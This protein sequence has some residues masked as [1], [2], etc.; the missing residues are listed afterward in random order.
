[1]K[2]GEMSFREWLSHANVPVADSATDKHHYYWRLD[3]KHQGG[4]AQWV[5]DDLAPVFGRPPTRDPP[6]FIVDV[7]GHRGINCRAG[8]RGG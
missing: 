7:E 2:W 1:M 8:M 5:Y 6:D 3:W 4:A